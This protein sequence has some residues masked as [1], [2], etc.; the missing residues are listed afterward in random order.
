LKFP[1]GPGRTPNAGFT[2]PELLVSTAIAALLVALALPSF[3]QGFSETSLAT[4]SREMSA[5]LQQTRSE[6]LTRGQTVVFQLTLEESAG[7][8]FLAGWRIS[9]GNTDIQV[10]ELDR[11]DVAI[12][13]DTDNVSFDARGELAATDPVSLALSQGELNQRC[14]T[15]EMTGLV[16]VDDNCD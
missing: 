4:V 14:I 6:A 3:R 10:Q 11:A 16:T 8:T 9:A 2:L 5:A 1:P 7:D 13:Q 15:V 12:S